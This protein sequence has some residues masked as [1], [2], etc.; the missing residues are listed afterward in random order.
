MKPLAFI[1]DMDGVIIDSNDFHTQAWYS[2]LSQYGVSA[3]SMMERMH[4]KRNDQIVRDVFGPHLRE[5]ETF[6]HGA[7]KEA[8][9]RERMRPHVRTKLV[10]GLIPF[11]E[12]HSY[13]PM[14]VAS[15][16]EPANLDFVLDEAC[17]RPFFRVAVNGHQVQRPKP[18]PE[19]YLR[20]AALL[21]V[22]PNRCLVFEDSA[23]GIAAAKGAG[24]KVV[25]VRTTD[26]V[27]PETDLAIRDF[28]D[29][30][31]DAWLQEL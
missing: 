1:L 30:A 10:R 5:A 23:T 24:A 7:A 27:L 13:L 11:L 18:D 29:P 26:A 15:N 4:G 9:Y 31:L 20:V 3:D 8:L 19:I 22:A 25:A 14:G 28:A 2:Y 6:A 21:N 17:I 12:K 16:A